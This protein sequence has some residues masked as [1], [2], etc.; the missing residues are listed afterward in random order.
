MDFPA[1]WLL[2][3]VL[4][5]LEMH[6]RFPFFPFSR[7]FRREPE[8]VTDAPH[9]LDPGQSLPITLIIKDADKYP[10]ILK[11]IELDITSESGTTETIEKTYNRRIQTHWFSD[12]I[13][14]KPGENTSGFVSITP[15]IH[16]VIRGKN[17]TTQTHNVRNSPDFSLQTYIDP[18]P[19]PGS[20]KFLWGDLHYHS[21]Y[22]EDYVEF[23]APLEA[24]QR[25]AKALGLNFVAITDHSYDLDDLPGKWT[26]NDPDQARWHESRERIRALNRKRNEQTVLLPAEEVTTFNAHRENVHTLLLNHPDYFPGSGDSAEQFFQTDSEHTVTDIADATTDTSAA[27]AAHPFVKTSILERILLRRG[28]WTRADNQISGLTGFQILN[29]AWDAATEEGIRIWTQLL[30]Q[31]EKRFVFAGNDAHGNFNRFHQI[32][33]PMISTHQHDHQILGQCRTGILVDRSES[34]TSETIVNSI[35]RGQA[36]I[37]DGPSLN[38]VVKSESSGVHS[39]FG[40]MSPAGSLIIDLNAESSSNFGNIQRITVY[41]GLI[42]NYAEDVLFD[43]SFDASGASNPGESFHNILSFSHTWD[44]S[45]GYIRGELITTN[46]RRCLTNPIWIQSGL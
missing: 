42:G 40:D 35:K 18:D 21:E 28:R 45:A 1:L 6:Y 43:Q 29:G 12:I 19:L 38:I 14:W 13:D 25:T 32:R 7:Y 4:G 2:V 44:V 11:K 26:E 15:K 17:R 31:G 36:I 5:Y 16:Y 22:T 34:L 39:G 37:T 27:I 33:L 30:L 10:I 8:I 20:D 9:R 24:T 46:Q 23:G 41:R 3:P